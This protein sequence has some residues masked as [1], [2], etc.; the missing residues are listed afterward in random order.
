MA[1]VARK[2]AGRMVGRFGGG[3]GGRGA[4]HQDKPTIWSGAPGRWPGSGWRDW[5]PDAGSDNAPPTGLG[6]VALGGGGQDD[7]N[8]APSG[9]GGVASGGGGQD[10]DNAAPS[11]LGGETKADRKLETLGGKNNLV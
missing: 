7:D 9:L 5:V 2:R 6:G 3:W 1:E 8:A 10:D 11:G 4:Q